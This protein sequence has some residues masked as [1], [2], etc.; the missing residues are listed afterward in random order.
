MNDLEIEKIVFEIIINKL[1]IPKT[2][3]TFDSTL[4]DLLADSLDK[5]EIIIELELAFGIT[6]PD[7]IMT[8]DQKIEI[9]CEYI[10]KNL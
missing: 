2:E 5:V 4:K 10:R 1:G 9:L 7:N 6:I 8:K 3:I